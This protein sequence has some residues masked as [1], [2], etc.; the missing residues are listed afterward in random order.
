MERN[1]EK[2]RESV[3]VFDHISGE[4]VTQR[5]TYDKARKELMFAR[6]HLG[7]SHTV[8]R[9]TISISQLGSKSDAELARE[10][11]PGWAALAAPGTWACRLRRRKADKE[12]LDGIGTK[13]HKPGNTGGCAAGL[14]NCRKAL[15]GPPHRW[16]A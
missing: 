7:L 15:K 9:N 13:G 2:G 10:I 11:K 12:Y 14:K 4:E 3:R 6:E 16:K 5:F 8:Y 1:L